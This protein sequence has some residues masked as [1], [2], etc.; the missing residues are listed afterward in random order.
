MARAHIS[1]VQKRQDEEEAGM[2]TL[3]KRREAAKNTRF[4]SLAPTALIKPSCQDKV[5]INGN[6]QGGSSNFKNQKVPM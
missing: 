6:K 1:L 5:G 2:A 4:T 3:V